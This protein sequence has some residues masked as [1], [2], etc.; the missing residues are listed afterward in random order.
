MTV[1]QP[2]ISFFS[3]F[4]LGIVALLRR[5]QGEISEEIFKLVFSLFILIMIIKTLK[6]RESCIH[7]PFN[8]I[9][10]S[11]NIYITSTKVKFHRVKIKI[12]VKKL[13]NYP[14]ESP[15]CCTNSKA[16]NK[17]LWR[18]DLLPNCCKF[19]PVALEFSYDPNVSDGTRIRLRMGLKQALNQN[20]AGC[21]ELTHWVNSLLS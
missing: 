16:P 18:S 6:I 3:Q 11:I 12:S 13:R 2:S 17:G 20:C 15:F 19:C 1:F 8:L 4:Y 10:I 9:L 7:V 14:K 21:T 5:C